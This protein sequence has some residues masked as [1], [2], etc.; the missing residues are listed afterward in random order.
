MKQAKVS[1]SN[2]LIPEGWLL[3]Y[4]GNIRKESVIELSIF[5]YVI[6]M[7]YLCTT[8]WYNYEFNINYK[9]TD[10]VSIK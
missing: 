10:F 4:A 2:T 8:K 3:E 1:I 5:G 9:K 7:H 6:Q